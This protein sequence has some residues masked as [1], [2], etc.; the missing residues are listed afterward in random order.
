MFTSSNTDE[1]KVVDILH[2]VEHVL[3]MVG[4][5]LVLYF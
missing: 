3:H 1:V 5:I 2:L 4:A